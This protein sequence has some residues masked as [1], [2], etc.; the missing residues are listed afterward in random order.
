MLGEQV[1]DPVAPSAAA[2]Q[3]QGDLGVRLRAGHEFR[4]EEGQSQSGCPG[5]EITA[6]ATARNADSSTEFNC[7]IIFEFPWWDSGGAGGVRVSNYPSPPRPRMQAAGEVESLE[8]RA[9]AG[10]SLPSTLNSQLNGTDICLTCFSFLLSGLITRFGHQLVRL[11]PSFALTWFEAVGSVADFM[12]SNCR[13]HVVVKRDELLPWD[14]G[15]HGTER[16]QRPHRSLEADL[17]WIFAMPGRR[18]RN[19]R[20]DQVV[21]QQNGPRSPCAPCREFGS[22]AHP[23]SSSSSGNAD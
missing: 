19:H 8:L 14:V 22:E 18:L 9:R 16:L 17:T 11:G 12:R 23:Y 13:E 15:K 6:A 2:D 21:R 10:N 1:G 5:E 7:S 4:T 3:G 20:S